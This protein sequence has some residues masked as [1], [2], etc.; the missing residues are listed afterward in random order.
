MLLRASGEH[1]GKPHNLQRIVEDAAGSNT[2]P[3]TAPLLAYADAF[4][5]GDAALLAAR[6]EELHAAVGAAALVDA[7][8]I[9]A[10]FTAVVR[11]AD[12]TGIPLEDFKIE[13]SVELRAELG[14]DSYGAAASSSPESPERR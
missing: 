4:V 2:V 11:I 3:Q 8:G 6:R 9:V 10:I 13:A 1:D 14:I 5:S 12:G 7:A